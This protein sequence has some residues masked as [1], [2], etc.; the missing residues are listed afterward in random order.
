MAIL[1]LA[2]PCAARAAEEIDIA[3]EYTCRG[4]NPGGGTYTGKVAVTKTDQTYKILWTIG[5]E[6]HIGTAIR[7][8]NVLS[9]CYASK[10][11]IGVVAYKIDKREDGARL[12]GRW[13]GLGGQKTQSETLTRDTPLPGK[14]NHGP[15][16][17]TRALPPPATEVS[18]TLQ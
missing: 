13:A 17:F 10:G 8:G 15:P 14:G 12:V 3:G 16:R 18:L 11:G 1:V 7:E 6:K 9:V 4:N 2:C 5:S